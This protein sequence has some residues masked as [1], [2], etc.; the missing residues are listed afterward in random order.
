MPTI[1][2]WLRWATSGW[3]SIKMQVDAKAEAMGLE[4]YSEAPDLYRF[5]GWGLVGINLACNVMYRPGDGDY[6]KDLGRIVA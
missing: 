5:H 1:P 4:T 3:Q 6:E 2:F